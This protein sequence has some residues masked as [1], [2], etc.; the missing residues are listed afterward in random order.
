LKPLE[1]VAML[2]RGG[3]FRDFQGKISG[4]SSNGNTSRVFGNY[5]KYF[6]EY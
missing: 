6:G 2:T 4:R 3:K 5:H 1:K